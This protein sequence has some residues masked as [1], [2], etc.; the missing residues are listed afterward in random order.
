MAVLRLI[1]NVKSLDED[2]LEKQTYQKHL[3][4]FFG[5]VIKG[6]Y[7]IATLPTYQTAVNNY[8]SWLEEQNKYIWEIK[9]DQYDLFSNH[10]QNNIKKS[11]VANYNTYLSNFYDWLISRK[12]DE[13]YEKYGVQV[14]NPVDAWNT[15]RLSSSLED[16]P[17]LPDAEVVHYYL[18]M[19]KQAIKKAIEE[20]NNRAANILS[21]Q[22][23]A[24]YIM[25][26]AGL[27]LAEVANLN[28]G[29]ISLQDMLLIVKDGKGSK[30]RIVDIPSD[31]GK[32]LKW[33]LSEAH[34]KKCQGKTLDAKTPLFL[35][36]QNKRISKKTLQ[37]KMWHQLREF[38]VPIDQHFSPHGLRRLYATNLYKI[39][40]EEKHPDPLTYIKIQLGHVFYST[41]LKYCRVEKAI[42]S[43]VNNQ[44]FNSIRTNLLGEKRS[45]DNN[46]ES[47]TCD[48]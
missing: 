21:R 14:V 36:E 26:K 18:Q 17:E 42:V 3:I 16:L 41:T 12:K 23:T 4:S 9:P 38:N 10:L 43:R 29:H 19:E 20:C 8:L 5:E 33:Y 40:T 34:P 22:I 2:I 48:V 11:T 31:L 25:L 6:K 45:D 32:V 35:S 28:V 30:D 1:K 39:L 46:M 13:I 15:P 47:N 37:S 24:E 44:A 7:A 27:R